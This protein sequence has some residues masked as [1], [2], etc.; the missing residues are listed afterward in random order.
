MKVISKIVPVI[1]LMKEL[2]FGI[3]ILISVMFFCK[4]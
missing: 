4:N 2:D 1:I 3:E